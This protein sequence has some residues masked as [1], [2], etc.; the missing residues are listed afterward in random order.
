MRQALVRATLLVCLLSLSVSAKFLVNDYLIT[1]KAEVVLNQMSNEL[2]TKTGISAY[3]LA[4]TAK[5]KQGTNLYEFVKQYESNTSEPY[6]ILVFAPNAIISKGS[7][8]T[9]RLGLIPSSEALKSTYDRDSVLRYF[10]EFIGSDDSNSLQSK[11]DVAV[12]HAYSELADELAASRE[13]TLETT[14]KDRYGWITK[15]FLWIVRAGAVILFWIYF[16]RPLYARIRY[17]KQ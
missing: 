9:G 14:L 17:G 8:Q 6:V 10:N 13:I 3:V 1:P 7:S 11:Y 5:L 4:T 15:I 2:H 16:V 12:L